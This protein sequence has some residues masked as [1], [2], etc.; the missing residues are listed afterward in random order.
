MSS[1]SES[2]LNRIYALYDDRRWRECIAACTE[3]IAAE[4]EPT[5]DEWYRVRT[6]LAG[7][8]VQFEGSAEFRE[9]AAAAIRGMEQIVDSERLPSSD[10]RRGLAFRSL[11]YLYSKIEQGEA[12]EN[13][14]RSVESYEKAVS[15]LRPDQ[16]G[17]EWAEATVGLGT[18]LLKRARMLTREEIARNADEIES[19]KNSV[20]AAIAEFERALNIYT[21]ENHPDERQ[22]TVE[23][24]G[25]AHEI[26]D[27]LNRQ[28]RLLH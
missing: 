3:A 19:A 25:A 26:L 18:Q 24:I 8:A 13:H 15:I 21:E 4:R 10:E 11:G 6:I 16:A 20:N 23:L 14:R 1:A 27:I 2:L 7:V 5:V 12:F 28:E 17:Q 9:A 22:T